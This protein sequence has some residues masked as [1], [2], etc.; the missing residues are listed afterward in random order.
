M[1]GIISVATLIIGGVIVADILS[2]PAGTA[3]ASS[4][5]GNLWS[6]SLGGLLG[7]APKK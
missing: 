2:H 3:A 5:I 6:S 1:S 7:Q 4:G